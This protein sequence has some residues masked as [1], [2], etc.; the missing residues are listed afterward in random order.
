MNSRTSSFAVTSFVAIVMLSACA[1][2]GAIISSPD[3]RLTGIELTSADFSQQEFLLGFHVS[4]PN[5]FPLPVKSVSYRI[6]LGEQQFA[7]GRTQGNFTVPSNGD[8]T[9]AIS[10]EVD[11]LRTTT[12]LSGFLPGS[13]REEL[14]Y[15]L[16]GSLAVDIPFAKPLHFSHSDSIDL[17]SAGL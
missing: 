10:V 6:R 3:V 7:S 11:L 14:N 12:N 5:P 4:N 17:L 15:E 8:S 9:F 13:T 1:G 2:S 16:S